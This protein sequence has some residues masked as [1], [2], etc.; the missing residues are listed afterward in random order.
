MH[1][2]PAIGCDLSNTSSRCSHTRLGITRECSVLVLWTVK[3]VQGAKEAK[4][5]VDSAGF[6]HPGLDIVYIRT[7]S[8]TRKSLFQPCHLLVLEKSGVCMV[9][10][11]QAVSWKEGDAV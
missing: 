8:R 7:C 9:L 1:P 4:C 11:G 10:I 2:W 6:V 5:F 3:L